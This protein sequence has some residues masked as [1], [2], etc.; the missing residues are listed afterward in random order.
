MIDEGIFDNKSEFYRF[1][2]ELLLDSLRDEY[3]PEMVNY[4][5]LTDTLDSQREKKDATEDISGFYRS[6]TT[7][8]RC[9]RRGDISAAEEHIDSRYPPERGE[10]LLLEAL[11]DYY[12]Q[13]LST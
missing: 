7:V 5:Q 11:L 2:S 6:A 3:T 9:A 4:D 13:D 1:A 12:R 8:R 10:Y